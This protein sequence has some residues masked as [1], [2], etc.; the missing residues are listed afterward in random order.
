[1]FDQLIP[2][3]K[4]LISGLSA[5]PLSRNKKKSIGKH[6]SSL[7][8]DLIILFDNGDNILRLFRKHNNGK[9]VDI[10]EIKTLLLEQHILIPRITSVLRKK[11]IQTV[12]SIKTP[13]IQP[14]QFFL[15]NKGSR[16]KFYLEKID[17][18]ERHRADGANIE[19]IRPRARV[20]IP[21]NNAINRSRKQLRKI[22]SL[23]E[24]LRL[25]IIEN[26]EINEII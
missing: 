5:L 20:E 9:N 26:F 25:F 14:L 24:E 4:L 8:R 21:D 10:D 19:W 7:H 3:G 1:M 17:E 23:T 18:Q 6:L 11:D 16:V 12:L 15:F 2:V 13:Q 22:K